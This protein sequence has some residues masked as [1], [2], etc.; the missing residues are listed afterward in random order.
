VIEKKSCIIHPCST[1]PQF[2]PS[3]L[4][5]AGG[6]TFSGCPSVLLFLCPKFVRVPLIQACLN[7]CTMQIL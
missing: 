4:L 3:S 6:I 1:V 2:M 5:D 7:L